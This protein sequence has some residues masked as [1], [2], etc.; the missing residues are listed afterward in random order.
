MAKALKYE[1]RT[2]ECA[3]E[4]RTATLLLEW[5]EEGGK[6]TLV[7]VE[8]DNPNLRGLE[9]YVCRW[10]CWHTLAPAAAKKAKAEPVRKAAEKTAPPK[11]RAKKKSP[12]AAR[13]R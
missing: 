8:C 10:S 5:K 3:E 6:R 13:K 9:P 11:K 7:G 4:H 2:M 12:P 1:R